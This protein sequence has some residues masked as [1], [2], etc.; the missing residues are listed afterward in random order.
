MNHENLKTS[1]CGEELRNVFLC[2][3]ASTNTVCLFGGGET[4]WGGMGRGVV[5]KTG[6]GSGKAKCSSLGVYMRD[7]PHFC[8]LLRTIFVVCA[9]GFY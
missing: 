1:Y 4:G 3:H 8:G 7:V 9:A 5:K 6:C 2:V